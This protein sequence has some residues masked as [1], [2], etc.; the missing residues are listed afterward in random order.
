MPELPKTVRQRLV[1]A[2]AE[3]FAGIKIVNG[4]R[5]DLGNRISIWRTDPFEDD[6]LPALD[7]K[8]KA[9]TSKPAGSTAKH[10]HELKMEGYLEVAEAEATPER[11]RLYL[12]DIQTAVGMTTAGNQPGR[13]W[14]GLAIDTRP[15]DSTMQVV[16][17]KN[18]V[19]GI[20]FSYTIVYRTLAFDPYT[21]AN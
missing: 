17:D 3:R 6:Q 4:F 7:L 2:Q 18:F 14:G 20:K 21:A 12:A 19:G 10:E 15:G 11:L 1:E 5:T 9:E 8:D 13:K 16:R